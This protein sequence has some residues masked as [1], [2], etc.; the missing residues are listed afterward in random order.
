MAAPNYRRDETD[1]DR[2]ATGAT[3]G[4]L[5]H[6][7]ELRSRLIKACLAIAVGMVLSYAFK[8]RIADIVLA[9]ML[10]A[11]PAGVAL[12][13]TRPGEGFA[14]FLDLSLMGGVIVAAPFVSWQAWQFIAP[15]LYRNE[16]RLVL[17]FLVLAIG[18][19]I[20]GALFSHFLLFP[21]LMAFFRSFDSPVMRFMPR[22]EDT[23]ALYKNTLIGMVV[24]FQI[25][26]LVYVL[27]KMRIV[28]ARFLWRHLNYA[29]LIAV[30]GAALLTPS[31]DPW[32]QLVF[33]APMI[34]MYIVGVAIAWLVQPK[35][36]PEADGRGGSALEVVIA[37]T[38][39]EQARRQR[40]AQRRPS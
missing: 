28:T 12:I 4:F 5:E 18:G 38:V 34:A 21:S 30:V 17:P 11:L 10:A 37:A 22:V 31:P 35:A 25:P 32:N 19:T 1:D 33:A 20:G 3:M 24:V 14:F 15:G 9:P 6:L 36:E 40:A 29:V 39:F 27:A 23:F 2:E 13:T 26:T 8:E 7:D 16:K